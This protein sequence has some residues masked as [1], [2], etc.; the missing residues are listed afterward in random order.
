LEAFRDLLEKR[1]CVKRKPGVGQSDRW[2]RTI[3]RVDPKVWARPKI[4]MP[5][6]VRSPRIAL[7][8]A[9]HL[10]SHGIYAVFSDAW[11]LP[12]LRD[13]L[14]SGIF[15]LVMEC[16]A[17]RL[18][19]NYKRCYKRFLSRL[20]LPLWDGLAQRARS[21]LAAACADHD[22]IRISEII[23]RLYEVDVELLSRFATSDW[24]A[25]T[26]PGRLRGSAR[27]VEI[28]RTI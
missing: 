27:T 5:E 24:R 8:D 25:S 23:A 14:A 18:N 2:Y 17:P 10:P 20:P 26:D 7:D 12:V 11:P 9:G 16:I 21:D 28:S 15:G 3:D 6:I 1:A 13:L 19:G 4:L 22:R